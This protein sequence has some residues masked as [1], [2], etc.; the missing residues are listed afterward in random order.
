M[1][2]L[3][4]YIA[5]ICLIL[6]NCSQKS[7]ELVKYERLGRNEFYIFKI[8]QGFEKYMLLPDNELYF[9]FPDSSVFYITTQTRS[10]KFNQNKFD[11]SAMS[12][13]NLR[14]TDSISFKGIDKNIKYWKH[15][16]LKNASYGYEFVPLEKLALFDSIVN[17]MNIEAKAKE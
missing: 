3:F 9:L 10:S 11:T 1:K 6:T 17:D 4:F 16:R 15:I 12:L 13:F 7:F 8:P 5:S 14:M 2:T